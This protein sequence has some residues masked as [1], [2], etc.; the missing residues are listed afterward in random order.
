MKQLLDALKTLEGKKID[1]PT[2]KE[3]ISS[4]NLNDL[5]YEE[6]LEGVDLDKYN[7]I[8]ISDAPLQVYIMTWP[9]QFLLPIHEHK[10]FWGYVI[11]LKGIV[12][13]TLYGYAPNKRK[14]FLHPTK[15][16]KPGEIIYEPYNAIHKLQNPSPI[17]PTISLHIYYPPSYDYKG[18]MIFD[19]QNRRLAILSEKAPGISWEMPDDHYESVIEDAY[20]VEKLW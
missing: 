5:P 16:F 6:R 13:E 11:P 8:L 12:A 2:V 3:V 17:E 7:R 9:P 4:V 1:P 20:D 10:N 15:S 18:T 19:A 14:I